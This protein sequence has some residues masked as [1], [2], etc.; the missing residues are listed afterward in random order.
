MGKIT[1]DIN[2]EFCYELVC[3]V[4]Y[5]YYLHK[6]NLLEKIIT[7]KGMSPFYYFC[8]NIEEK[9]SFRSLDNN[10]NGVQNLPNNWLHHNAPAVFNKGYGELSEQQQLQALGVLDYSQWEVPP[11][12][13][14]FKNKKY[15]FKKPVIIICNQ[16][17]PYERGMNPLTRYFDVVCLYNI[18]SYL[19]EQG[20][21]VIYKRPTNDE[22]IKDQNELHTT[23]AKPIGIGFEAEIEGKLI[24]DRQ[25][26]SYFDDVILFDDIMQGTDY[27][28]SQLEIFAHADGFI[29]VSGG[30]G[31]L[32]SY[33]QKPTF[34]YATVSKETNPSYWQPSG[35]YQQISNNNAIPV[36]DKHTD[37]RMRNGHDYSE[38]MEKIKNKFKRIL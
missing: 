3:T 36:I 5:A 2:P 7:C 4:P 33:F 25:L 16:W 32:C 12:N 19:S 17:L 37:I 28:L 8:D 21:T 30:N 23:S 31:I 38:L 22:F 20:Y 34:M 13:E 14:Y 9:Y 11:Y 1:I 27:N 35:Y 24:D 10:S 26:T 15:N 29:S 6:N 18:F